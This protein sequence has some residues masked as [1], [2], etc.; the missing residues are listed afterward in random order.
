[1]KN[2]RFFV[3]KMEGKLGKKCFNV[4][5]KAGAADLIIDRTIRKVIVCFHLARFIEKHG[6]LWGGGTG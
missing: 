3:Q 4:S 2:G 5:N 1:M 6:K